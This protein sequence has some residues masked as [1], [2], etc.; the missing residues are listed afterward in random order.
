MFTTL[1]AVAVMKYVQEGVVRSV[2]EA[3]RTLTHELLR[4]VGNSATPPPN[5]FR[6]QQCYT[7][8]VEH[9]LKLHE[10]SL[11]VLF[12]ALCEARGPAK[13]LLSFRKWSLFL[14]RLR[15]LGDDLS[16]RDAA[17]CFV[18]SRTMLANP[19]ERAEKAAVK[20]TYL[21]F[22]GFV[23]GEGRASPCAIA[24][25]VRLRDCRETLTHCHHRRHAPP[26]PPPPPPPP[27]PLGSADRQTK[28]HACPLC[29]RCPQRS[30]AWRRS[31]RC[32]PTT[33]LHLA[34]LRTP[35]PS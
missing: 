35:P 2:S 23:E 24:R 1:S 5:S 19:Y 29:V 15:L 4:H 30:V 31:R 16:E 22:E 7:V 8:H 11:R 17:L 18:W 25:A 12:G 32:R 13:G 28:H 20:E 33:R 10:R 21:P 26:P 34:A 9:T 27:K 6:E 3:L 14:R